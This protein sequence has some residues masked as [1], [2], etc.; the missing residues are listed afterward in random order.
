VE[1]VGKSFKSI[2][3]LESFLKNA[4]QDCMEYEVAE[5]VKSTMAMWAEPD[6][7]AKYAPKRYE[8]TYALS[9]KLFYDA[10]SVGDMKIAVT[11]H[12]PFNPIGAVDGEST[13]IGEE[14][15]IH[16]GDG[17]GGHRYLWE[18]GDR[19][20]KAPRPW[21][22]DAFEDLNG[23]GSAAAALAMGLQNKGISVK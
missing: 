4:I 18:I 13:G 20:Y 2:G 5:E 3:D 15:L 21:I 14:E 23:S 6:V 19:P 1:K 12:I 10:E 9:N 16:Y 8:R 11:P 22:P 17:G 7:Y